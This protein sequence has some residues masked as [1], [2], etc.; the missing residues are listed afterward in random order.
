M[1]Q[2]PNGCLFCPN[3]E[4]GWHYTDAGQGRLLIL[5][6][7]IG[8]SHV[9]WKMVVPNLAKE[10][11]VLAF[12]IA[13]FGSTP[14]LTNIQQTPANLVASLAETLSR[15]DEEKQISEEY[16]SLDIVGNSLGGFMALEAAKLG[17]LGR[18]HVNSIVALSPAGLWRERFPF[19]SEIVLQ[20]TRLGVRL[21]PRLTNALLR[22]ERTRKLLMAIPVSPDVPEADALELI[23]IF[24]SAPIFASKAAL[25]N[26]RESMKAPFTGGNTIS[27]STRVTIT[28]GKRDLLLPP[29]ARLRHEIPEAENVIW[30]EGQ[31]RWAHVPMWDDPEGVAKF[32]LEGTAA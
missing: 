28:F 6:H 15:I 13:G 17:K 31:E 5:L 20:F 18:F 1:V 4:F 22:R 25:N 16:N 23:N 24:D 8:M 12:D 27:R 19:R 26:F 14:L 3:H 29:S 7:G 30:R 11:R 10:R 2:S 21:L 9:A 32:I